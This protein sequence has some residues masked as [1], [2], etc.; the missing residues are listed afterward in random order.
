M[1]TNPRQRLLILG[2][3]VLLFAILYP[4]ARYVERKP[5]PCHA[6]VLK[7]REHGRYDARAQERRGLYRDCII[8]A[9]KTGKLGDYEFAPADL[10]SCREVFKPAAQE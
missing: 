9:L 1:A 10:D 5:P 3:V 7:C 6:L 2:A 8:E 4:I